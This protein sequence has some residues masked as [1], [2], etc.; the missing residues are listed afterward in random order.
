M[1]T[2]QQ[3]AP[4]ILHAHFERDV[5]LWQ[6][7]RG[8]DVVKDGALPSATLDPMLELR[9]VELRMGAVSV[10]LAAAD[11]SPADLAYAMSCNWQLC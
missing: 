7:R 8:D 1:P 9:G 4:P 6:L 5:L 10:R 3:L 2:T 11:L